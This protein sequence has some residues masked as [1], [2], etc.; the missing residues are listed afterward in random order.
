MRGFSNAPADHLRPSP[1][2][3]DFQPEPAAAPAL[4]L[5][6]DIDSGWTGLE[7][8]RGWPVPIVIAGNHEF[9]ERR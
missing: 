3:R 8:F 4:V 6:G 1:R 2:D 7:R 5:A 9:D